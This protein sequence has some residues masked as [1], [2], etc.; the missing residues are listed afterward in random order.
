MKSIEEIKNNH[1]IKEHFENLKKKEKILNSFWN[2]PLLDKLVQDV[3]NSEMVLTSE[4]WKYFPEKIRSKFGWGD[5]IYD[6]HINTFIMCLS[7][8]D[9]PK[10]APDSIA[11][12][13]LLDNLIMY[14]KGL[15]IV[16]VVGDELEI[17]IGKR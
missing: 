7:S 4:D 10:D 3:I 16:F 5:D 15:K 6:Q 8:E 2:Y 12:H 17:S 13:C 11:E 1:K 14:R 9:F